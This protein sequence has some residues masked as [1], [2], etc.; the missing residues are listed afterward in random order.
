MV[1]H[2]KQLRNWIPVF[3]ILALFTL[4]LKLP[5]IP[6]IFGFFKC[7]LC[8][9]NNPYLVFAGAGYFAILVAISLLFPSLP[10]PLFARGGLV[11][12]ILLALTLT[13]LALPNLCVACLI[14]HIFNIFIWT[15]WILIPA[16]EKKLPTSL[17]GQRVCLL[18]FVPI[19]VVA[20]FSCLNLTFMAY[21]FKNHSL[22]STGLK[23]GDSIPTF[24]TPTS[25]DLF[26]SNSSS[27][28]GIV[29]NFVSP[30]CLYCKQQLPILDAVST[31][32]ANDAYRFINISPELSPELIQYAPTAEWFEDKD[33]ILRKLFKVSGYPTMFIVKSDGKIAE[34]ILGV[35]EQLKASLFLNLDQLRGN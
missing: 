32:S 29:F 15:I 17:P 34:I 1:P 13:Y 18:L 35:P 26:V 16:E 28:K 11:W 22:F 10:G 31:Q 30:G 5:E 4:F 14:C 3:G 8:L 6:N 9:S 24:P 21:G 33:E 23:V 12:A 20:L 7:T 19:S 2:L 25:D 27:I